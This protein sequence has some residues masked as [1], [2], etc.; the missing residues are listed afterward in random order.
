MADESEGAKKMKVKFETVQ[1]W[2]AK[3]NKIK[4]VSFDY[5]RKINFGDKFVINSKKKGL[6]K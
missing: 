5:K 2:L 3:G 4:V 1:E 6:K